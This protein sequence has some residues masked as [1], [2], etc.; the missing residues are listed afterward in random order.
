MTD[1]IIQ[2]HGV[3]IWRHHNESD[4]HFRKRIKR[5]RLGMKIVNRIHRKASQR[6]HGRLPYTRHIV[7]IIK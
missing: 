7:E 3:V 5:A 1:F 4:K 6:A 2:S